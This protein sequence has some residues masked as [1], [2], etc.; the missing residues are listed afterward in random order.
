[1]NDG[2]ALLRSNTERKFRK[3]GMPS[4]SDIIQI[5][6]DSHETTRVLKASSCDA[7][8]KAICVGLKLLP[9]L[10]SKHLKN[11]KLFF[12]AVQERC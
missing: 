2:T 9:F 1:M 4:V 7:T 11:F 8:F 10:I 3:I 5:R 6:K 12:L